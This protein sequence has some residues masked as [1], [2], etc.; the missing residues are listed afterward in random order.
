MSRSNPTSLAELLAD[1]A[2]VRRVAAAL[3]REPADADDVAQLTWVAALERPPAAAPDDDARPWLATVAR[4][5][6]RMMGRGAARR[7][8]REE[9]A[10]S[11][12]SGSV[13]SPEALVERAQLQ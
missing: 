2:W 8:R 10:S 3:V 11:V 13:P 7:Q 5:I 6:A 4:N 1:G 12:P 9:V